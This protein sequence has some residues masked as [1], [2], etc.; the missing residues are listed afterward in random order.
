V[1]RAGGRGDPVTVSIRYLD[2][3]RVPFVG[4]LVGPGVTMHARVAARQEFG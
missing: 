3:V 1:A 4:W 2:P